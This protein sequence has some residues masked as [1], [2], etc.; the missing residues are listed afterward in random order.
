MVSGIW[1][2]YFRL[3]CSMPSRC[4]TNKADIF[5]ARPTLSQLRDFS[6]RRRT[7]QNYTKH[8]DILILRVKKLVYLVGYQISL[9]NGSRLEIFLFFS[10]RRIQYQHRTNFNYPTD[11]FRIWEPHNPS[12]DELYA[13]HKRQSCLGSCGRFGR[14]ILQ[15][16]SSPENQSLL[17]DPVRT[18]ETT[19]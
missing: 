10:F 6:I 4:Q 1:I 19:F 3:K 17:P 14:E 15:E 18:K 16:G 2:I 8:A 9:N 5:G 12:I 11:P 13:V 7:F